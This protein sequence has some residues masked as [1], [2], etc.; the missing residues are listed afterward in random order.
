MSKPE[1]DCPRRCRAVPDCFTLNDDCPLREL[2][3]E[4]SYLLD[5]LLFCAEH[6]DTDPCADNRQSTRTR[7]ETLA[8]AI[9]TRDAM[10]KLGGKKPL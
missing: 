3:R 10:K 6:P 1:L 2:F 8:E 7:K 9:E 5:D 4:Y